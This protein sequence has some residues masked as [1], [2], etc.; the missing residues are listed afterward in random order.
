MNSPMHFAS[1]TAKAAIT[2]KIMETFNVCVGNL[3]WLMVDR[4]LK[5]KILFMFIEL[6]VNEFIESDGTASMIINTTTCK[7]LGNG[8]FK[9]CF[10]ARKHTENKVAIKQLKQ[11]HI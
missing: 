4:K 9:E 6:G 3:M 1:I 7:D 2:V 10:L 11:G 5:A 8:G